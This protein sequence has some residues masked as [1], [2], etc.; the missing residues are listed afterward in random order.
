VAPTVLWEL[1][2]EVIPI[3]V[4]PDGTNINRDCGAT[5]PQAMCKAVLAHGADLGIAVDGDADRLILAD[6]KG[7]ILDGDQLMGI[8]A[9]SWSA[10][11]RLAGSAIVATVMSNLGLERYLAG[12]GVGLHRTPVG[13]RYVV[14][15]M[16][17]GGFNVGGEQSGHIILSDYVTTG[18]GLIAAL[19][20]LAVLVAAQKPASEAGRIFEPFPQRL[21]SLQF[22]GAT[23]PLEAHAVK[24]AIRAAEAALGV[25][26][27]VLIRKSGTEP[28]I[29]VMAEGEDETLV[30]RVVDDIA[31]AIEA[32]TRS[33]V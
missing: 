24:E 4:E 6:E 28:V 8:V 27:R 22:D 3:G 2:A 20:V 16:R 7:K 13:D 1:G 12:L 30:H 5:S 10:A 21:K 26:G 18:D 11:G 33:A 32:Q 25:A 14:E 17:A 29:R 23:Q 15:R 9:R 19:Q 31:Q